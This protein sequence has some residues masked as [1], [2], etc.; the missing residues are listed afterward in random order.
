MVAA[1]TRGPAR[2]RAP[3]IKRTLD[4]QRVAKAIAGPGIDTRSWLEAGT[5]GILNDQ[6]EFVTGDGGGDGAAAEAR[7]A[8][9]CERDGAVV[10]LRL[11]PSGQFVTARYHGISAGRYG[12]IFVPLTPGDEVVVAI[13]GGD[14]NSPAITIVAIASNETAQIPA[15][16]ANDRLLIETIRGPLHLR[17]PAIRLDSPNLILNG[18][19][20]ASGTEPI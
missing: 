1:R 15:D 4:V 19:T 20:V 5:V 8:V 18:R 10:D 9:A 3:G 12:G 6:G 11:E 2:I 14:Y 17:G 13:P 7:D 16:W